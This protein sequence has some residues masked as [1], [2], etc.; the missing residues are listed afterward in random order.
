MAFTSLADTAFDVCFENTLVGRGMFPFSALLTGHLAHA[1]CA[2]RHNN[3]RERLL[4]TSVNL[5]SRA[6]N[7]FAT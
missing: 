6:A 3:I 4:T 2:S 7:R 1:L 5:Q